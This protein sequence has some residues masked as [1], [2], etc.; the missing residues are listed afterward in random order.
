MAKLDRIIPRID[1]VKERLD[2]IP[3]IIKRF[4]QAVLAAPVTGKLTEEWRE[5]NPDS[6][7]ETECHLIEQ[8]FGQYIDDGVINRTKFEETSGNEL[9]S[10]NL[11]KSWATPKTGRIFRFIESYHICDEMICRTFYNFNVEVNHFGF[12]TDQYQIKNWSEND[13]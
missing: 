2:K 12:L 7:G 11:P 8:I 9:V 13:K 5:E 6:N 4:R 10:S 3:V 1:K